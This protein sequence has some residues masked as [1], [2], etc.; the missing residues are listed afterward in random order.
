MLTEKRPRGFV[1]FFATGRVKPSPT[2]VNFVLAA[3]FIFMGT[4]SQMYK[5]YPMTKM[6]PMTDPHIY[7]SSLRYT[8]PD[9]WSL[10]R[11]LVPHD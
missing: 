9:D 10:V 5:L 3:H 7:Q 11:H 8:V 6:Y 2:M 1:L 4:G